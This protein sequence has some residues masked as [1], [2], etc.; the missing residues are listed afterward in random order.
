M[1]IPTGNFGN[2][3]ARSPQLADLPRGNP[4]GDAAQRTGQIAQNVVIDGA[5]ANT[6]L[7]LKERDEEMRRR[8]KVEAEELRQQK[9]IKAAADR[10]KMITT[11]N[12]TKDKLADLHDEIG[13]GVLD[14]TVPK[15]KAE[16]EFASR[17]AKVLEGIGT[18]LPEHI[19]PLV[20]AELQG[21][22]AKL[23]NGVRKQ[24]TQR[25][26]Q[27]VTSGITQTLEYLQ[28]QYKAD[29]VKATQ[30][31]M[32]TLDQ[33]GA[34]STLNPEQVAKA[35]Q[36]WKEG[37][38][39]TAAYE[40]VSAGR[41]DPKL[42]DAAERA[43]A[44]GF[45]D[46]D[47]QKRASLG[48]RI[49]S[50]RM[51]HLQK[52]ELAAARAEREGE[53]RLKKAEAEFNVFQSLADKGTVMAPE[54]ID[55]ALSATS[56][57]P[58]AAG[59]RALAQQAAAGAGV[60]AQPIPRQLQMLDEVNAL[61]AKNGRSPELDKRR[62]QIEKIVRGSEQDVEKDGLRAGLERGVITELRPLD[63]SKGV[64]GTV[65][66]LLERVPLA[67]RVSMWAGRRVSPMT[68][69]ES[70]KFKAQLDALPAKERAGVV[71]AV[72]QAV[73]PQAAQ[74]L[75]AQMD[76]KD[77]AL[78]LSFA[79]STMQTSQGRYTSELVLRGQQAKLDGTSTKGAKQPDL[80]VSG[81]SAHIAEELDGVFP[82]QTL[83][84]QTREAAVLI[85]HGI[86]SEQGGELSKK[87]LTRAVSL[88]LGGNI[89]EYNG[90]KMPL[91]AGVT[92]D[93]LEKRV[94]SVTVDELRKQAPEGLVR[95]GG[96]AVPLDQFVKTLP[97]Q[98]LL[99][100][101]PGKYAVIVGGRP[102]LNGANRPIVIGVQ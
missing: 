17:S 57:T 3:V 15:E 88:A 24:V 89:V 86:A 81:W 102:V 39:F 63:L 27:D 22:A 30:Q 87:D 5:E 66:Q 99:Y 68:D 84:D 52:A 51:H 44:G 78:A 20:A 75:A 43:I 29:P 54:Y 85:A 38:Q 11:L 25:N 94:K 4:I 48:D 21:D 59:I 80:K 64:P 41:S 73:G 71:A 82:A 42:L 19:R 91:P 69:E 46:L 61:I 55:R 100:A 70:S 23:A 53:R 60:A 67:E 8:E 13:Q 36:T 76:K 56:G 33:L 49:S 72:A 10:A 16:S 79:F 12:G 35:K 6:R 28:R 97:G 62:E 31:A 14:G 58:Y 90:R 9:E 7:Q 1:Q 50:Y 37:T 92:Q 18:D 32:D 2:T 74:G 98:Q 34:H 40:L 65:Q 93:M 101:G 83:T 45:P 96:V 77:K 47:P 26:R 95:A